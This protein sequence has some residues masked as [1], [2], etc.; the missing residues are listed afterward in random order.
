[1]TYTKLCQRMGTV[2]EIAGN[3]A[4]SASGDRTEQQGFVF[5]RKNSDTPVEEIVCRGTTA[6]ESM[7]GTDTAGSNVPVGNGIGAAVTELI[8]QPHIARQAAVVP[9]AAMSEAGTMKT[10]ARTRNR[11]HIDGGDNDGKQK[12]HPFERRTGR[13]AR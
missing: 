9:A 2:Q 3:T 4:V 6:S 8:I 5:G 11:T 7:C 12:T 13:A 1:M 10:K